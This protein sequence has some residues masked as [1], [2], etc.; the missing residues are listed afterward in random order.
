M[1]CKLQNYLILFS[2][3]IKF[4][5][6]LFLCLFAT[7]KLRLSTYTCTPSGNLTTPAY[8]RCKLSLSVLKHFFLSPHQRGVKNS[9]FYTP[10]FLA[11][12]VFLNK[13]LQLFKGLLAY[14]V[15]DF[16]AVLV[17]GFFVYADCHKCGCYCAVAFVNVLCNL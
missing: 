6:S 5:F 4:D 16:A 8:R 3:L 12:F 10:N 9:V 14:I 1:V 17:G 15:F 13:I 2:S 11:Y 7:N